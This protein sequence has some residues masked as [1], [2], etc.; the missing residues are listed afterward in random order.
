M[1]PPSTLITMLSTRNWVSTSDPRA[2]I[3]M[4]MPISRVRSVTETIMM[5][6]IPMP[7]TSSEIDAI[8]ASSSDMTSVVPCAASAS[9]SWLR[10]VKSSSSA[11]PSACDS[12]MI[13][14][15]SC[16]AAGRSSAE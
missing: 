5:F 9:W 8:A 3:A 16:C 14:R 2:P 6:M 1:T 15:I 11:V 13:A 10:M 4:R 7:P 12:R